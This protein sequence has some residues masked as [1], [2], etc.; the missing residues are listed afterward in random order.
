MSHYKQ[1]IYL[2]AFF[3]FFYSG[4]LVA[5]P[6]W[7]LKPFGDEK[8]P[9]KY[10]EKKLA[11]EKTGDKKFTFFKRFV[12]N[13]TTRYNYYFNATNKL[14]AVIA[15]AKAAQKDDYSRLL[16][17]YP[18]SLDNTS[19]QKTELDSVIYKSTAGV[20]LHDLRSDWVDN[21]YMLIGEAYFYKK[22]FDSAALTFQF[23]NYN[24]YPRKKGDDGYGR[25]VGGNGDASNGALSIANNEDRNFLQKALA[26]PPSR[27]DALL[28]LARTY[29]QQGDF[30]EA[31]GLINILQ[32]D[33]NLPERLQNNLEETQA[34]WFYAQHQYD[35]SAIHLQNALSV[36]DSKEDLSRWEYLLAQM[37]ERGGKFDEASKYYGKAAIH[38]TSPVL[39]IYAR[40]SDA[41]MM[42][43]S[44]NIKEL[45]EAISRLLNMA[46]K[47]RY[48]GY[49]DIIFY[50]AAQLSLQRPD[51]INAMGM[52]GKG[53][54][55]KL[56][57]AGYRNR[58][59]LQM[60]N[61]SFAQKDYRHAAAYYDSLNYTAEDIKELNED[62][63]DRKITLGLVVEK[64]NAID[65]EDS[66]Q[67]IAAL[68]PQDREAFIKRLIRQYRKA[69]GLKDEDVSGAN[70]AFVMP[71]TGGIPTTDLFAVNNSGEWYFYNSSLR[72]R[73]FATF[74]TKW[75]K[76]DNADNWRRK[77]STLANFGQNIASGL[78]DPAL[79]PTNLNGDI[80]KDEAGK[81]LTYSYD[82]LMSD[83][84]MTADAITTSNAVIATNLLSLAK[85]FQNELQDYSK[86]IETYTEYLR[87][88]G[89][90]EN[91]A[92]A[93][94]GLY[95]SYSKIGNTI[96]A[97]QY[98]NELANNYA[99][100]T[101][102]QMIQNPG[103][104]QPNKKNEV[105]TKRY[106]DIYNMFVEGNFAQAVAEKKQAD[107]LYGTNYWTPQLLYIESI[108]YIKQ[109]EDSNAIKSL[110]NIQNLYP[111]SEL[112][113]KATTMIDVLKRRTEIENYLTNL[114]VT[115]AEEDKLV[116]VNDNQKS[117][118]T[119]ATPVTPQKPKTVTAP[120]VPAIKADSSAVVLKKFVSG[121]YKLD[122]SDKHVVIMVLNK[123]DP[124]YINEAKNAL[125]RY[126]NESVSTRSLVLNRDTLDAQQ[127]IILIGKFVDA[128]A[129]LKYFKSIKK[130][131]PGEMSWLPAAKYSFYIITESNLEI[132][133]DK[134]NLD[135]YKKLLNNN[136]DNIF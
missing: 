54:S 94:L 112:G 85:L 129:A 82:A 95:F 28:W 55:Y 50:S 42:R 6:T 62:Y 87:R 131:A 46:R 31:A 73:G 22:E 23:I 39:E 21:M 76:R 130:A 93:L 107:S 18:Y 78:T 80:K 38:T 13:N 26:P 97:N 5:Q 90:K 29:T 52:Y 65:R 17:F 3:L 27:N 124:V 88:F 47:D 67:R 101:Q 4:F 66:L 19:T 69:N 33:P 96:K 45:D 120:T 16:S 108:Y 136:Y 98:K 118:T 53:I 11:S 32:Q 117:I 100:S 40:L 57:N 56:E 104:L 49:Q 9:E 128:D 135:D 115:R 15:T 105:V 43:N 7:T 34:F 123:V 119:N 10:E 106:A 64:L 14:D 79:A 12:Q 127:A 81:P 121:S 68:P 71:N 60:A 133:K 102:N 59:Y 116:V 84:P 58:S 24:L 92:E 126:N 36:A 109:R 1:K 75:G 89:N 70:G 122:A 41:K 63:T 125:K 134:K 91:D 111:D 99:G 132:L 83:L 8:K 61:I 74:K 48:D 110:Q 30:G 114:Q 77:A 72:S 51:T 20:L 35:S 86:A 25:V 103:L 44:G 113:A 37:L 2:L